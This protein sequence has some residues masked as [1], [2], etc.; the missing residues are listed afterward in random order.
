MYVKFIFNYT[1]LHKRDDCDE[2]EKTVFV[3]DELELA[4]DAV[5]TTDVVASL[6]PTVTA[7]RRQLQQRRIVSHYR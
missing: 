3:T 7:V 2:V 1:L 4:L 5:F 6:L